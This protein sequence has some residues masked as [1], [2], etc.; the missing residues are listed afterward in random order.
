VL[1][2]DVESSIVVDNESRT[3]GYTSVM[4]DIPDAALAYAYPIGVDRSECRE[5]SLQRGND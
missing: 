2:V 4:R 1:N 3:H 5:H